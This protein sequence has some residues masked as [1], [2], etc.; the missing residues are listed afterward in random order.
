MLLS[1]H[2]YFGILKLDLVNVND[3]V[4]MEVLR[5]AGITKDEVKELLRNSDL[6]GNAL[7]IVKNYINNIRFN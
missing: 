6:Y 1:L 7:N 2:F 5:G 4:C 3:S